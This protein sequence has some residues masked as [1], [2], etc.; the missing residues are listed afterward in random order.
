MC[1]PKPGTRLHSEFTL[2]ERGKIYKKNIQHK[3]V[4]LRRKLQISHQKETSLPGRGSGFM[5][6]HTVL[7]KLCAALCVCWCDVL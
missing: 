5:E 4:Q 1:R 3:E 7:I 2:R 6:D